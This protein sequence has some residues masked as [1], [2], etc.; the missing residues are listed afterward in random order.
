MNTL[1]SKY[2]NKSVDKDDSNMKA[3]EELTAKIA[4]KSSPPEYPIMQVLIE[5]S[6]H[7]VL[8]LDKNGKVIFHNLSA[9]NLLK[10]KDL[11]DKNVTE[12]LG[13]ENET[14]IKDFIF[15]FPEHN[16]TKIDL[17]SSREG[18]VFD[19]LAY[20]VKNGEIC[21][22]VFLINCLENV[23]FRS[24]NCPMK[25]NCPFNYKCQILKGDIKQ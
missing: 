25:E 21:F 4:A 8:G 3:L 22:I 12:V 10:N 2:F 20:R 9:T 11:R 17:D 14:A 23:L 7:G 6:E 24:D 19:V 13:K 16:V 1:F 15:G 5:L 18:Q